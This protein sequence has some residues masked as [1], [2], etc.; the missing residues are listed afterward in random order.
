MQSIAWVCGKQGRSRERAQIYTQVLQLGKGVLSLEQQVGIKNM[1]GVAYRGLGKDKQAELLY[2]E[3]LKI[4]QNELSEDFWL[5]PIIKHNLAVSYLCQR[6]YNEAEQLLKE[7]I[8][9]DED[10]EDYAGINPHLYKSLG[11]TYREQ[12]QYDEAEKILNEALKEIRLQR[13]DKHP[14]TLPFMLYLAQVH[15]KQ[16]RYEEAEKLLLEA[17]DGP[18]VKLGD[19]HSSTLKILKNL[20][21]LY[22]AWN[23]PEEAK[24]WW[25]KLSET[26]AERE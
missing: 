18:C 2:D 10:S 15:I 7:L 3:I 16:E 12:G 21:A 1:L 19:T 13:G 24:K 9:A 26:E 22:E 14:I 25:A 4:V 17:I 20:I 5:L 6:R 8:R 23:K 11:V